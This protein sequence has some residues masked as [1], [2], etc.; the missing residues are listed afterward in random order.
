MLN[1][2]KS[3]LLSSSLFFSATACDYPKSSTSWLPPADFKADK[4]QGEM[5]YAKYCQRCHGEKGK[6]SNS[7]PPLVHK[8]YEPAHHADVSFYLAVKNGVKAH[9]WTF[10]NMPP[11]SIN[12]E[13][14]AHILAYIRNLQRRAGIR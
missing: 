13:Q 14:T 6:G 12:P 10:G 4:F 8:I 11:I 3:L 2:K 7:G 9:H 1:A 5:L